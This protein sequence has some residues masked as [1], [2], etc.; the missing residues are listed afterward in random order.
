MA[1]LVYPSSRESSLVTACNSRFQ[2]TVDL[3]DQDKLPALILQMRICNKMLRSLNL[4]EELNLKY[5]ESMSFYGS[6]DSF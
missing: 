4:L 3:V 1:L 2:S 5:N 6:K